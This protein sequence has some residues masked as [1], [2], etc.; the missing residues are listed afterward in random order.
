MAELLAD[1]EVVLQQH[2]ASLLKMSVNFTH[3]FIYVFIC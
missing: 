1:D 2:V 3:L